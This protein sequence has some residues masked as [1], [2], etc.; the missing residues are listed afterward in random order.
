LCGVSQRADHERGEPIGAHRRA[1]RDYH[2]RGI[3]ERSDCPT[4]VCE[5]AEATSGRASRGNPTTRTPSIH[6]RAFDR[7]GDALR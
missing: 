1:R 7:L 2:L 3:A 4:L 6:Q 5:A